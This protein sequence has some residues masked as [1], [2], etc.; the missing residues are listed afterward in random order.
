MFNESGGL[1]GQGGMSESMFPN[2]TAS[3]D[4]P[5]TPE[6][7]EKAMA[8]VQYNKVVTVKKVEVCTYNL[9]KPDEVKSYVKTRKRIM[10]GMQTNTI[11]LVFA[12]RQFVEA[13]PGYIAHMEWI[14]YDLKVDPIASATGALKGDT[15]NGQAST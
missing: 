6:E 8:A 12:D 3:G 15:D 11:A 13:I 4:R 2:M 7:V 10:G 5:P 9:S 1:S 14:E